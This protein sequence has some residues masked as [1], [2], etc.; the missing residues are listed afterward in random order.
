MRF[1]SYAAQW[2]V[3][4][5]QFRRAVLGLSVVTLG[6]GQEEV[7]LAVSGAARRVLSPELG[8]RNHR[9]LRAAVTVKIIPAD[10]LK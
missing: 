3:R 2:K 9:P 4:W 8:G 1:Y 6:P 5:L 7:R 10:S